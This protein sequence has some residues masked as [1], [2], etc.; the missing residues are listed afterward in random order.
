MDLPR[1][2]YRR[3]GNAPAR[4]VGDADLGWVLQGYLRQSLPDYMVPAAIMVLECWPLTP[5]GKLDRQAL[6]A[7]DEA[8]FAPRG[9]YM[10]PRSP[11]EVEMAAIWAEVLQLPQVGIHDNFFDFGG[12]SLMAIRLFSLIR[13]HFRRDLP[14][15]SLFLRPTIAEFTELVDPLPNREPAESSSSPMRVWW[16]TI[17]ASFETLYKLIIII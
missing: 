16:T 1:N 2:F 3:Y 11:T 14:L 13:E 17:R 6:T 12:H 7:T 9:T 8:G 5:S 4:S 15:S 10:A